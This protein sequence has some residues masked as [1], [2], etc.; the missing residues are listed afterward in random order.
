MRTM[1][2]VLPLLL[3]GCERA[4]DPAPSA[5]PALVLTQPE[6]Q[7]RVAE[8]VVQKEPGWKIVEGTPLKLQTPGNYSIDLPLE[9]AYKFYEKSPERL[10]KLIEEEAQ[11]SIAGFKLAETNDD[12]LSDYRKASPYLLPGVVPAESAP[13]PGVILRPFSKHLSVIYYYD[14]AE[15][16][17]RVILKPEQLAKWKITAE[18][19]HKKAVENLAKLAKTTIQ[20]KNFGQSDTTYYYLEPK[21]DYAASR[22]LLT[23][24]LEAMAARAGDDIRFWVPARDLL[25]GVAAHKVTTVKVLQQ[26][27][28]N[29][30][31]EAEEPLTTAGFV[32]HRGARKVEEI[33]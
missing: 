20:E 31:N 14:K 3:S 22:I 29:L 30:T 23:P 8:R 16:P 33:P 2:L 26:V 27:S 19:L 7:R 32:Y 1:L 21:D 5:T 12:S 17:I 18:T 4:R 11:G 28:G 6:F 24:A 13:A 25:W 9:R 10:E 15:S